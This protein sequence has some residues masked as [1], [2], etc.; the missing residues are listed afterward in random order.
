MAN[1]RGGLLAQ[2][3]AEVLDDEVALS[4][5]LQK[6]IVLGGK[7][8]SEKMRAW[9]RQ[10]LNGYSDLDSVPEYRRVPVP[11]MAFVTNR[12]G[13]NGRPVRID[14]SIFPDPI[15]K[16]IREEFNDLEVAVLNEGIGVLEAM[17]SQGKEEQRLIPHWSS[18]IVNLMN[19]R[20]M[21]VNGRVAEVYWS[22][23]TVSIQG[24]LVGIRTALA[25]LVA[26]LI[27][28]TPQ[29]QEV[30]DRNAADQAIQFML[31]GDRPTVNYIVQHAADGGTNVTV[32][33]GDKARPV[34]V[35]GKDGSAIGSQTASG[36]NSSVAGSQEASGT[37]SSVIGGQSVHAGRDAVAAG[38]YAAVPGAGDQPAKE[39][40]WARL[41]KRGAIVAF[42]TV[43]GALAGV[44][45]VVIAIMIA[46]GWKP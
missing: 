19:Q 35:A 39:G 34:T 18:G 27:T 1:K 43:I 9:A 31:T 33:G 44:A 25:E 26:E 22:V 11:L 5:L 13:Y 15:Q 38:Q 7:A 23:P 16:V 24:V 32:N 14:D 30:P 20:D 17:A 40:W 37:N 3:E 29:D 2:I 4:S 28:L 12:G 42:A 36:A 8:R 21:T 10:E 41:R 46:A 45:G 6:C